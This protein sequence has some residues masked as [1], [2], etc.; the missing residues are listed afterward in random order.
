MMDCLL[1]S[2]AVARARLV[3]RRTIEVLMIVTVSSWTS[4]SLRNVQM[5]QS[6]TQCDVCL[7]VGLRCNWFPCPRLGVTAHARNRPVRATL[8]LA[9]SEAR[10]TLYL[11]ARP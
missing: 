3:A 2:P 4:D 8:G 11:P 5:S 10:N 1:M 7:S 6:L 9:R